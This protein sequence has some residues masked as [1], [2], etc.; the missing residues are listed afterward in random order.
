[1][2]QYIFLPIR[3]TAQAPLYSLAHYCSYHVYMYLL[4]TGLG[5]LDF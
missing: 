2:L 3:R 1:M 4:K 5:I